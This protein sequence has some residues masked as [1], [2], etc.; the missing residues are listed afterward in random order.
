MLKNIFNK[1]KAQTLVEFALVGILVGL[2][3]FW[4]LYRL[5]PDFFRSYFR[6][7]ISSSS[8]IDS[9]GQIELKS[10][11]DAA[12]PSPP[13]SCLP[14]TIGAQEVDGS[15][16]AGNFSGHDICMTEYDAGGTQW[17]NGNSPSITTGATNSSDGESNVAILLALSNSESPYVAAQ[18]CDTLTAHGHTDW[19][20][21]SKDEF[22]FIL[23]IVDSCHNFNMSVHYWLSTE[24]S[25]TKA[26][27][28]GTH[29]SSFEDKSKNESY[30]VRCIRHD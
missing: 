11:D 29:S 30:P 10:M 19:Y 24:Y 2:V 23:S 16:Y 18:L 27:V 6:G 15:Y 9:N 25:C 21:P 14:I 12:A 4:A 1:K 3:S 28:Y 26:W 5:N 8:G 20:L 17:N 7:S 13:A 22:N